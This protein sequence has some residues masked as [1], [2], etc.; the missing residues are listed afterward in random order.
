MLGCCWHATTPPLADLSKAGRGS[1]HSGAT[2]SSWLK[3]HNVGTLVSE[4]A[5]AKAAVNRE[6]GLPSYPGIWVCYSCGGGAGSLIF[7]TDGEQLPSKRAGPEPTAGR[8]QTLKE[9]VGV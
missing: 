8:L 6:L 3:V 5:N 1:D 2:P 7:L 4:R 9:T